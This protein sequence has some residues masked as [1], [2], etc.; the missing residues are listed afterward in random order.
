M[1]FS[2]LP[3]RSSNALPAASTGQD[4]PAEYAVSNEVAMTIQPSSTPFAGAPDLPALRTIFSKLLDVFVESR[5]RSAD[6][7]IAR[8]LHNHKRLE[9]EYRCELERRFTGQ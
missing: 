6:R 9:A 1:T 3:R 7:E 5:Q 4:R 2:A 8:H